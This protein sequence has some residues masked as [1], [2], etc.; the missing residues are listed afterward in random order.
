MYDIEFGNRL[1]DLR[2]AKATRT[3]Q[4]LTQKVVARELGV[5][6]GTYASWES[7]RNK[8]RINDLP[9]IADYFQVS[10]DYLLGRAE[11]IQPKRAAYASE[12]GLC[13]S[14]RRKPNTLNEQ[15]GVEIWR[16]LANGEGLDAIKREFQMDSREMSRYLRDTVYAD[17]ID[18]DI[19]R[20]P[21]DAELAEQV[22][23]QFKLSRGVR[24]V[25]FVVV[26]TPF[27][28]LGEEFRAPASTFRSVLLGE[29]ARHYFLEQVQSRMIR[30][31]GIA[32]GFTIS[33]MVYALRRGECRGLDIF[34]LATSPVIEAIDID[35]NT[36]VGVFAYRHSGYGVR[37]HAL[38]YAD[39]QDLRQTENPW[40][41]APTMSILARARSVEM[42]FMGLGSLERQRLPI[43]WLDDLLRSKG[44]SMEGI[45]QDNPVG[46]VLYHLVDSEGNEVGRE[47]ND[48]ICSIS[49]EDLK[50]LIQMGCK[51]V[52]V[53]AGRQKAAV[54]RAA[55][56]ARYANVLI[57]DDELAE[58]LLE[59]ETKQS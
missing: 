13:W 7:G 34:P 35:A 42:A 40:R 51:V 21:L 58:G 3:G 56:K 54:T 16:C 18:I 48:L 53:A 30:T 52:A 46:D 44:L 57:I 55:I 43:N 9:D 22:R 2:D 38:Q 5:K 29:V 17:L 36:L 26:R 59:P 8:P 14:L 47:I 50:A 39:S 12:S 45:R 32:G 1:K 37:G 4:K 15:K 11:G 49:L 41:F 19:E 24:L 27:K 20:L 23:Q 10:I 6:A 31:V 33:R 25:D 28:T